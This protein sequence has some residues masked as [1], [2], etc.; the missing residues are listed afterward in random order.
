MKKIILLSILSLAAFELTKPVSVKEPEA[1][2]VGKEL[3]AYYQHFTFPDKTR[4][5]LKSK[6][7]LDAKG[8]EELAKKQWE[9]IKQAELNQ[10]EPCP[11][12]GGS[13]FLP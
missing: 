11:H 2:I 4:Q 7:F 10:P 1:W 9:S 8:W 3:V 12:C 5:Q 6:T 13:G